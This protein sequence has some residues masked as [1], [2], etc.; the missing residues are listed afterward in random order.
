ML[1]RARVKLLMTQKEISRKVG[2]S[3]SSWS[4]YERKVQ[5]MSVPVL[6]R[7]VS[8]LK[9]HGISVCADDIVCR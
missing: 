7:I 2:V 3:Q 5:V 4:N 9:E 1:R 8:F 6:V